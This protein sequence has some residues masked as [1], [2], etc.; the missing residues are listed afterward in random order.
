MNT[1]GAKKRY[2]TCSGL[3]VACRLKVEIY[4]PPTKVKTGSIGPMWKPLN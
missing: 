2:E 3:E 1:G 4:A